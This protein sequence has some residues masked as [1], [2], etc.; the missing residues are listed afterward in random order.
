MVIAGAYARGAAVL[1]GIVA[2]VVRQASALQAWTAT[3]SHS[4]FPT[5][6]SLWRTAHPRSASADSL[7]RASVWPSVPPAPPQ[8]RPPGRGSGV[9]HQRRRDS[10]R[11]VLLAALALIC[12]AQ[13]VAAS[14]AGPSCPLLVGPRSI[15]FGDVPVGSGDGLRGASLLALSQDVGSTETLA[16]SLSFAPSP[17][18]VDG[19]SGTAS[20]EVSLPP[21]WVDDHLIRCIPEG[22]GPVHGEIIVTAPGCP[23][24]AIALACAGIAVTPSPRPTV[25]PTPTSTPVVCAGDCDGD[26]QVT[27]EELLRGIGMALGLASVEPCAA[28]A[29]CNEPGCVTIAD[30]V[31]AVAAALGACPL[32]PGTPTGDH[33]RGR[34]GDDH[35][36]GYSDGDCH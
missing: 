9:R 22:P 10:A 21:E 30:L 2:T 17:P 25:T 20:A 12:G 32:P 3:P 26:W 7:V 28:F 6:T 35:G 15:D 27:I 16:V 24:I 29:G 8:R 1:A 11:V 23:A 18:F 14:T 33:S 5:P 13:R 4:A 19:L 36:A 34:D 31:R